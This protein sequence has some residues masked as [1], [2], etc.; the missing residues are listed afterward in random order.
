MNSADPSGRHGRHGPGGLDR[1][2]FLGVAAAG[3]AGIAVGTVAGCD[4]A[5]EDPAAA[6]PDRTDAT[7][8]APRSSGA[9]DAEERARPGSPDWRI[10]SKGPPDAVLG[11]TDRVSV[12][13]GEEFGL[14]VSTTAPG[15][16]VSAYRVG[17]YGG[18]QARLVWRSGRIRGRAQRG[19][20][21][22]RATR[23][24]RAGWRRTMA[25]DTD[26]WPEGAYLLRLDAENGHQRYVPLIVRSASGAGRTVL[27]HAPATWQA[28]N[29]WG[30]RSL[31]EGRGGAYATRSL[32][33]GFDRPYDKNGAEKFLVY[34]RAAVVLA[35]RLGIPL[36]YTTG[37]DVHRGP[38]VLRGAAAAVSLG[39]DEYWTPEQRRHFTEARD[40]G[41]NLAF[42]GANTCFR[43]VRLEGGD[44]PVR[45]VVCYKTDYALDPYLAGHSSTATTDFR[46]PPAAD[47]ESSLTGVLYEGFPVDAPYVVHRPDHWVF[48]GAGA[49]RGASFAHLVGVEYDRVTPDAP[50][51]SPLEIVAHSPLVCAGRRSHADS[52]YYT[53][54]GGAGVFSCGT[55]RW[56]EALMAGTRD[57]G[58]NHG[59]DTRTGAFVTRTT[60]NVL[61]AFAQ[62]PAARHRPAPRDNVREVYGRS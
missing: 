40:A 13:P 27:T 15:F 3:A 21:L 56:V 36:A 10:R 49:R 14:Y 6:H 33:V 37:I 8:T 51:P 24:V 32:A 35:D 55:M 1:R 23:T 5:G 53:T 46:Q 11:Y 58:R 62:G 25:V 7:A 47:P 2:H 54:P 48:A 16:R 17:W 28:Y 61:R 44:G 9:S 4:T 30:G 22:E 31:Y 39:H 50:T 43:R 20:S 29:L 34:E 45:T 41:T 26:G 19:P 18:A 57:N 42:L 52:A 12:L 60:E 38:E 59:L